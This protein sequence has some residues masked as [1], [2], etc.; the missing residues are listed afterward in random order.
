MLNTLHLQPTRTYC[1]KEPRPLRAGRLTIR[2]SDSNGLRRTRE[3]FLSLLRGDKGPSKSDRNKRLHYKGVKVHRV[4]TNFVVQTGDVT[5]N[6]GSGGEA[7]VSG[8]VF[9]AE[10]EGLNTTPRY[11]SVCMTNGGRKD[12]ITSQFFIV[13]TQDPDQ[14]KK[15]SNKQYVTFG[16]VLLELEEKGQE[17]E[18]E[19]NRRV[20][21]RWDLISTQ[22]GRPLEECWIEDCG[23]F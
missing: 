11:G 17:E 4:E 13:T 20:F 16:R 14:L 15:L 9:K 21:A 1:F 22:D 10:V 3:N 18:V 6:D 23:V 19:Q 8:G 12:S 7:T 5:R 2:L